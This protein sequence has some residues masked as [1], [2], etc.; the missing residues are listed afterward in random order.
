MLEYNHTAESTA[1]HTSFFNTDAEPQHP[2]S[3]PEEG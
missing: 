3:K 1:L 2:A